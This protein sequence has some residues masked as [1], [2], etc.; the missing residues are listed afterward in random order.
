MGSGS[1]SRNVLVAIG[2]LA[3][4]GLALALL[5]SRFGGSGKTP[6]GPS[7]SV[8]TP[9]PSEEEKP[10][11][12]QGGA[13]WVTIRYDE[14]VDRETITH[15]ERTVG[16]RLDEIAKSRSKTPKKDFSDLQ[17]YLEPF[18]FVCNDVVSAASP[19]EPIPFINVVADYPAGSRQ[20]AWAALFREGHYQLF[21]GGGKARLFLK[22]ED[23]ALLFERKMSVIR[24]PLRKMLEAAGAGRMSVEVHAFRNDYAT[25]TIRLDLNPYVVNLSLDR[26]VT[27]RKD[28]PLDELAEFFERDAALEAAEF[29]GDGNVRLFGTP[30]PRQTIAGS[31]Q[32]L[33]DFAVVYRSVFHHEG[34]PPYISLDRHEDNRYAKVN[35]GGFLEDTRVGS[36][37]LEADKLFKTMHTGLEPNTRRLV[38]ETIQNAVPDFATGAERSIRN[39][40]SGYIQTR[41]WFYPD[42]I[43]TVTDGR[44]G[45]VQSYRF[46]ADAERMDRKAPLGPSDRETIDHLNRNFERYAQVLPTYR[47]LNAVGRMMAVVN[48]LQRSGAAERADLDALLSVELSEFRTPRST[49][50]L[51]AIT[52]ESFLTGGP[53]GKTET[54]RKVVSLDNLHEALSPS[55]GDREILDIAIKRFYGTADPELIPPGM[56]KE[57]SA[58]AAEHRRIESMSVRLRS[59]EAAIERERERGNGTGGEH[60]TDRCRS[61]EEKYRALRAAHDNALESFHQSVRKMGLADTGIRTFTSVGGGINLR[62]KDFPEPVKAGDS[63]LIRRIR[64]GKDTVRSSPRGIGGFLRAMTPRPGESGAAKPPRGSWKSG[65]TGTKGTMTVERNRASG[66]TRYRVETQGYSSETTVNPGRNEVAIT[67]PAFPREIVATGN[68]SRGGTIVLRKGKA[69]RVGDSGRKSE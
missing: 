14:L 26:L 60:G 24:H 9:S 11:P 56:P 36:V 2:V 1:P 48:W 61:L 69:I 31:P 19:S 57:G 7:R 65:G 54:R 20:P 23:P 33:E 38:K 17:P 66:T 3:A 55:T 30:A 41:F 52:A 25:R 39:R 64:E 49:K 46:L 59:I 63:P 18:S 51:I 45:A 53:E 32:A 29:D 44:I 50:K 42:G 15:S 62:P 58:M 35:F 40:E 22:G 6:D 68:F 34:N 47:E 37:V 5:V 8:S 27:G 12:R 13:A 21:V 67:N 4:L 28:L 43:R 16:A 10:P